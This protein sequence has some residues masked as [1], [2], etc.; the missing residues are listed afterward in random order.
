MGGVA[1]VVGIALPDADGGKARRVERR[2]APLVSGEIGDAAHANLAG[3]P[4]ECRDERDA[5]VEVGRLARTVD[6]EEA[7]RAPGAAAVDAHAGVAVRHPLLRV[8]HLPRL[9]EVG[10]ASERVG[11]VACENLPRRLVA[12]LEGE[13]LAV[14]PIGEDG[15]ARS[16]VEWAEDVGAQHDTVVHD[17]RHVPLDAHAVAHHAPAALGR[18]IHRRRSSGLRRF[19]ATLR[20][21]VSACTFVGWDRPARPPCGK[22]R[23]G[24]KG[25]PV[26]RERRMP[27]AR[28]NRARTVGLVMVRRP[29]LIQRKDGGVAR[30]HFHPSGRHLRPAMA[31]DTGHFER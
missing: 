1:V 23:R 20:A 9:V 27:G 12:V 11:V 19:C 6:G 21:R 18:L 31:E 29:R 8:R 22:P 15:R 25:G 28:F 17:E 30:A 10:G 5:V 16:V 2:D 26:G 13:A 4:G 7:R 3:A 14:G 24:R